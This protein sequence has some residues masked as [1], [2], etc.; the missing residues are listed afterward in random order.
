MPYQQPRLPCM[1]CQK[2][3]AS[4]SVIVYP[5][6]PPARQFYDFH[7][8]AHEACFLDYQRTRV[9]PST[10]VPFILRLDR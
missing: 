9:L 6:P 1:F 7:R 4:V 3:G 10:T 8:D 2:T 5:D